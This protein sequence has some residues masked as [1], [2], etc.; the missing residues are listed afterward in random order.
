MNEKINHEKIYNCSNC[1]LKYI[2]IIYNELKKEINTY[3]ESIYS[4]FL[5]TSN[6]NIYDFIGTNC[7][8]LYF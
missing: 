5:N 3:N 7:K 1:K 4:I 8:I 2:C 6:V